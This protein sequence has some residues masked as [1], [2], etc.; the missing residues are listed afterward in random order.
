[1]T[2]RLAWLLLCLLGSSCAATPDNAAPAV[3]AANPH[4]PIP[5]T[6]PGDDALTCQAIESQIAEM[7]GRIAQANQRTRALA[8]AGIAGSGVSL[9]NAG[10]G[11]TGTN[12]NQEN[13]PVVGSTGSGSIGG[14]SAATTNEDAMAAQQRFAS[15]AISRANGL[16]VLGRSRKCF[17]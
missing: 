3:A 14:G 7:N 15:S 12:V 13:Y 1:M 10:S 4:P 9:G 6:E 16:I 2:T 11:V 8:S 5:A 17:A